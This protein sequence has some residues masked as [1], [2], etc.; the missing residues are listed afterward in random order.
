MFYRDENGLVNNRTIAREIAFWAFDEVKKPDHKLGVLLCE[1]DEN[2]IDKYVYE[3]VFPD[4]LVI[5]VGG[6]S[7][8]TRLIPRI[9]E[10]LSLCDMYAY[11][12]IDRDALSKKETKRLYQSKGIYTTKLPFIENII[13]SPEVL[14]YVCERQGISYY[15][16]LEKVQKE[17]VKILWQK[18]KEAL[19]INLGIEKNERILFLKI[20]AS[21]RVK[22]IEKIV[23]KSTILYSYRDKVITT[24]VATHI[25][26]K[27]KRAYYNYMLEMINDDQYRDALARAF[28]K[29]IPKLEL[30]DLN[31]P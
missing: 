19:P 31:K 7:N 25:G 9:R 10:L 14:R 1:G 5:P 27:G 23:D 29:F 15:D 17:L 18:L 11:A 13:C 21:T 16:T 12:I 8:V 2:S 3:I 6:C 26:I 24:I 4:L 30:Y 28:A 22:S 20:V